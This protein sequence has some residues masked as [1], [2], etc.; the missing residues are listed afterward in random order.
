M[1]LLY[2]W[3]ANIVAGLIGAW[4]G[5]GLL[6]TWGPSLA[7]QALIPSIIW[8][9]YFGSDC[10]I[11]CWSNRYKS[12]GILWTFLKVYLK[13]MIASTLIVGGVLIGGTVLAAKKVDGIGG[14][15]LQQNYMDNWPNYLY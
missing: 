12:G 8:G 10:F 11:S 2:G 15:T 1:V 13:F 3:I 14:D 4:I 7:W 6:S 9:N 5:Q